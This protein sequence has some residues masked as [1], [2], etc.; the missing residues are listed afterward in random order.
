MRIKHLLPLFLLV[1]LFSCDNDLEITD[2][3]KDVTVVYGLLDPNADTN[4]IRIERGY[5][6]SEPAQNSFDQP[7]SFYYNNLS[8]ELNWYDQNNDL[9]S[10]AQLIED[11]TSRQLN[12]NGP[13]SVQGDYRLYRV[14]VGTPMDINYEYEVVVT[15]PNEEVTT[16]RTSLLNSGSFLFLGSFVTQPPLGQPILRSSNMGFKNRNSEAAYYEAFMDFYWDEIDQ[17]TGITTSHSIRFKYGAQERTL[18]DEYLIAP[19]GGID[20]MFS[21]IASR[22]PVKANVLRRFDKIKVEVWGAD[23][24]LYTYATLNTPAT[25][26]NQ[27]RP[28]FT[29]I[30][31]GI[32]IFGSR[33][34]IELDDIVLSDV[35]SPLSLND[36]LI[37]NEE[38]CALR[39]MRFQGPDTCICK[40]TAGVPTPDCF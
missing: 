26:I 32:G 20:G 37:L 11:R 14:P 39:F 10:S 18:S 34:T 30:T 12:D 38:M 28:D 29:N 17:I 21:L 2:E 5:L 16:A 23:E 27:N 19:S 6:G 15:K 40:L 33:F 35:G 24:D 25:G 22:I 3:W 9:V 36:Q 1:A 13:F 31:N 7:D 8:V 4:F